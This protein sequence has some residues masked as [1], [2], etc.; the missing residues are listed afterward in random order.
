MDLVKDFEK[1][2]REKEIKRVQLRKEKEKKRVLNLEAEVFK[3]S[4][5]LKKYTKKILFGQN[6]GKFKN[7]YLKKQKEVR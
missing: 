6:N 2:I 5:L 7:E 4:K 3:K 1:E